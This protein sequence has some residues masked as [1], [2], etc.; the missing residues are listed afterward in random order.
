MGH[1]NAE[2]EKVFPDNKIPTLDT[3]MWMGEEDIGGQ[4]IPKVFYQFYEKPMRSDKVLLR[5]TAMS[6][7]D[8]R[9]SL[10]QDASRRLLNTEESL[11]VKIKEDIIN[12]YDKNLVQSG[13]SLEER[14]QIIESGVTNYERKRSRAKNSNKRIHRTANEVIQLLHKS[15][16]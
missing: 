14:R 8:L 6:W 16:L 3:T 11:P 12:E 4:K 15:V 10:A 13:Y 2:T 9:A 1:F 5:S 7:N